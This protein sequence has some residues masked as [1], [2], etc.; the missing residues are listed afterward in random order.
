MT[1]NMTKPEREAFL[2]DVHVGVI[3]IE[4]EGSAPLSAPIWYDYDP[5]VGLW[6]LT[7]P[8]SK[9][10]KALAICNRFTLVA[11]TETAPAYQYVCVTGRVSE[12]RTANFETDTRPMAERY[13]DSD[14][15]NAYLEMNAD[16]VSNYY[17]MLP[18]QWL[19]FDYTKLPTAA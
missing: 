3:S 9:K 19:T 17:L 16:E 8:D 2:R 10:G 15:A 18:E 11:Q 7:A 6:I 13:L 1:M 12:V 14:T 4:I 5:A